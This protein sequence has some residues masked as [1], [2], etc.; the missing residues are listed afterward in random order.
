MMPQESFAR[1]PRIAV[2]LLNLFAPFAQSETIS[3]DMQEEFSHIA[4][5][6]G[7]TSARRWYWRQAVKTIANLFT[8]GFSAAPWEITCAVLGGLL[9]AW[10]I[11]NWTFHALL[12][13]TREHGIHVQKRIAFLGTWV[14]TGLL[15]IAMLEMLLIG[16]VV[17]ISAKGREIVAT[18][19]MLL[20]QVA[21]L[22]VAAVWTIERGTVVITSTTHNPYFIA[23]L[24]PL[25]FLERLFM[26]VVGGLIVRVCRNSA[27]QRT[28]TI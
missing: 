12:V 13:V 22:C 27:I 10:F 4:A 9:L 20:I 21:V 15:A 5:K 8:S 18:M 16:C 3:G 7:I 24:L 6:S 14:N 25:Y 2:W 11:P 28:S 23:L 19:T 17:A 1:P 26:V